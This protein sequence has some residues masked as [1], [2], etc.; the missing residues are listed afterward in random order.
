[1]PQDNSASFLS[2]PSLRNRKLSWTVRRTGPESPWACERQRDWA[3]PLPRAV[4]LA[5]TLVNAFLDNEAQMNVEKFGPPEHLIF[6]STAFQPYLGQSKRKD[7][8]QIKNSASWRAPWRP[9]FLVPAQL[10]SVYLHIPTKINHALR[11]QL[12]N[13][14]WTPKLL[15]HMRR[16]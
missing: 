7:R 16:V 14:V 8:A 9:L 1:M 6:L 5:Q 11:W 4:P 10:G 15:L 2:A 13:L 12:I 3:S